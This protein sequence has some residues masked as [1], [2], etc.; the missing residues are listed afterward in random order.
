MRYLLKTIFLGLVVGTLARGEAAESGCDDLE[1]SRC[2]GV[3]DEKVASDG[4]LL[5]Y[6][7][8]RGSLPDT[9]GR[10]KDLSPSG[11]NA[12]IRPTAATPSRSRKS[13]DSA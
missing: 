3:A 1:R 6:D 11:I 7:F 9:N 5:D 8:G 10:I 4:L 2:V 13:I 12:V